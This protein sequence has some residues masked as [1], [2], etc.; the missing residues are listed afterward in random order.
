[1]PGDDIQTGGGHQSFFEENP[2]GSA[3]SCFFRSFHNAI[4]DRLNLFCAA[5]SPKIMKK[6]VD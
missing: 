2:A 1:M 6:A 4:V 3:G 5:G